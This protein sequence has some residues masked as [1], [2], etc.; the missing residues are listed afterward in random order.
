MVARK[1][2]APV[3]VHQ[4]RLPGHIRFVQ[5][6]HRGRDQVPA[7][8]RV[9]GRPHREKDGQ[10][11]DGGK[12]RG[13]GE[14]PGARRRHGGVQPELRGPHGGERVAVGVWKRTS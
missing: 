12:R 3:P 10:S 9:R 14:F 1:Q 6:S 13:Q 4:L 8:G 2:E 5:P 7:G 11:V